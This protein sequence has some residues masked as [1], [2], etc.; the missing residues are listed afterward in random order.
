MSQPDPTT[1]ATL[2]ERIINA[3]CSL[4]VFRCEDVEALHAQL[5]RDTLRSGQALYA[6]TGEAGLRSLRDR[7]LP[8]PGCRRFVDALRYIAQ[9]AHFGIYFCSGYTVPPDPALI[10]VL[11]QIGKLGGE[12]VRRVVLLDPISLPPTVDAVEVSLRAGSGAR[13]QL[14]DGRWLR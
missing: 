4:I 10:P 11:R 3:E 8:V 5:R 6:W 2:L 14:R 12:R 9:S 1:T 13:P 7:G